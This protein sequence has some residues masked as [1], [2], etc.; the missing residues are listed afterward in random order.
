MHIKLASFLSFC[1]LIFFLGC[2]KIDKEELEEY[3]AKDPIGILLQTIKENKIATDEEI[4]V[5][6]KAKTI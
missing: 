1:L 4:N 2:K 3:K 5:L 6:K